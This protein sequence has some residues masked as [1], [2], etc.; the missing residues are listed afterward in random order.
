M[1]RLA[2]L[3]S[4]CTCVKIN[5][6]S[7]SYSKNNYFCFN[8]SKYYY[9]IHLSVKTNF[10]LF[11]IIILTHNYILNT[12]AW[13]TTIGAAVVARVINVEGG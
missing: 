6:L 2:F 8:L 13:D 11:V 9:F 1:T 12:H 3:K 10:I 5:A 4:C 7:F